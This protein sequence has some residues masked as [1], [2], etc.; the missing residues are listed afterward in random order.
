MTIL[1]R[2]A[3]VAGLALAHELA[4]AGRKVV[5]ADIA[6]SPGLGAS[7]HAGGM[8]A[9]YCEGETASADVVRLGAQALDWWK[10]VLPGE[11]THEGTMVVA[12]ARDAAELRRFAS[13]TDNHVWLDTMAIAEKEPDL[14]GRFSQALFFADE[15]HLDPRTAMSAL[16][17]KLRSMD[18]ELLVGE[19]ARAVSDSGHTFETVIDCTG[20]AAL[21]H[22]LHLRG[23]R[24]EMV[25]VETREIRLSRPVRLLHP[26][27]PLY[28]VP[29]AADRFMIGATMIESEDDGPASVRSVMELLNAAYALHPAFAEARLIETGAGVRPAFPDNFPRFSRE[30]ANRYRLNGFYRHGF[31]LA[32]AMAAAAVR[33][34]GGLA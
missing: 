10:R 30:G 8:L 25:V 18:V 4:E 2:G 3:G 5:L 34:I 15:A 31:L 13:R 21:G 19:A 22:A 24:G 29:R 23:V 12:P 14:A 11:V 33:E 1:I 16:A 26:R 27:I 9:P 6:A 17:A 32:P 20:K 28:I 7:H